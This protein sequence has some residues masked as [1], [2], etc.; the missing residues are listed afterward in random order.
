M[1]SAGL[2]LLVCLCCVSFALVISIVWCALG[3]LCLF[4]VGGVLLVCL[5]CFLFVVVCGFLLVVY[6]VLICWFVL[7]VWALPGVGSWCGFFLVWFV[8]VLV[9]C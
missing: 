3:E 8:G 1:S 9:L 6:L 4:V 7:P 5:F 2:G